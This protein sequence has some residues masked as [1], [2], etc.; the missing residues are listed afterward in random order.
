MGITTVETQTKT[1]VTTMEKPHKRVS[2]FGG[3]FN[4]PH[5]AHLV[6][7]Q[8]IQEELEL[9]RIHFLPT[10]E[11]SHT[12]GKTT[13]PADYR[14]DMV[15]LAIE[16]NPNFCLDLTEV[17]R[18]GKSYTVETMR[19]LTEANPDVEYYFII[20]QDMVL[21]LPTWDGIDELMELVQFVAAKR[22][23]YEG[24]SPYPIIWVDVP[25]LALSSSLIRQR[26]S[27]GRSIQYLTPPRVIDYIKTEGL[28]THD[29]N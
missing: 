13:I 11:P 28:Y 6:I 3:T 20:G 22:P 8:H 29:N 21:D 24:E 10:A 27:E 9:D 15:E 23:G 17:S 16:D 5:Y 18:G 14:V 2:I 4:P 7:A 19:A 12:N 25:E 1:V 26:V